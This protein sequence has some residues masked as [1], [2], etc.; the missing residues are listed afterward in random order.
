MC[1]LHPVSRTTSEARAGLFNRRGG[2]SLSESERRR[3][4]GGQAGRLNPCT[5][6]IN[7]LRGQI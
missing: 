3:G 6:T 4:G 5:E 1:Q 7:P 2:L